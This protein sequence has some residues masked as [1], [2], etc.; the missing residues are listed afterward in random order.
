[1]ARYNCSREVAEKGLGGF[2][3]AE[4]DKEITKITPEEVKEYLVLYD[5]DVRVPEKNE[6]DQ[7]R[8]VREVEM[9]KQTISVGANDET[10]IMFLPENDYEPVPNAT[11]NGHQLF[12]PVR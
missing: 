12:R 10:A 8:I 1:M 4:P 2:M 9:H 6:S 5:T 3:K 7:D 11:P